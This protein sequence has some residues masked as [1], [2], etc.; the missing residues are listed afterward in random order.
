MASNRLRRRLLIAVLLAVVAVLV[1]LIV[2]PHPVAV[3]LGDVQRGPLVVTVDHEGISR[4]RD[5]FV[6]SAPVAGK[7]LRIELEPGDAVIARNT[8]VASFEPAAPVALDARSRAE[9]EAA[10]RAARARLDRSRA[11]REAAEAKRDFATDELDRITALHGSGLASR[12][13]LD[14]AATTARAAHEQLQAAESAV[15]GAIHDLESA[16]AALIEPGSTDDDGSRRGLRITSPV[17][18]VV[19][20]RYHESESIVP[21]GE[22][23]LEVADPSRMEVVADFLSSDAVRM[24]PGMSALIERW[25]GDR[26][27]DATVRRIEPAGFMKVSALGVEEQ[28]VNVIAD[29]DA[30]RSDWQALGDGYRVEMRVVLWDADDVLQVPTSALFRATDGGWSVFV[31]LDGVA[32]ARPVDIGHRNGQAAEVVSGLAAGDRVIVHPPDSV[33]D[34][35]RVVAHGE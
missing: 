28:R 9:A 24:R 3:D 12:Q 30:P 4:V 2:R 32:R 27:L 33:E 19:L 1:V 15:R 20:K 14:S 26:A 25:G 8:V 29:I 18:G 22:P 7:V 11:E 17:D 34:G 31:N 10:V 21:A 6:V 13:Q 16:N 23:L 35:T 5:R